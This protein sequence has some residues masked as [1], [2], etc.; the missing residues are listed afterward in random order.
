MKK[1]K[2]NTAAPSGAPLSE[3]ELEML[4]ASVQSEKVD[5]SKL[6]HYDNSDKAKFFRYVKKNKTF[7][8]AAV[9]VLVCIALVLTLCVETS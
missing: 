3:Q 4:R 6:P 5:R 7:A 2:K 8:A 9:V 1:N